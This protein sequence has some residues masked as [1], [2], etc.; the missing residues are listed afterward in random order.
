MSET[1]DKSGKPAPAT[2]TAAQPPNLLQF[3]TAEE[4]EKTKTLNKIYQELSENI[5]DFGF[6]VAIQKARQFNLGIKEVI[7]NTKG[8]DANLKTLQA[9]ARDVSDAM[10]EASRILNAYPQALKQAQ[11]EFITSAKAAEDLQEAADKQLQKVNELKRT[12]I[13]NQSAYLA[14]VAEE[15]K[16]LKD[17][18]YNTPE[19]N[20]RLADIQKQMVEMG[21]EEKN[22]ELEIE[23][24]NLRQLGTN[25]QIADKQKEIAKLEVARTKNLAEQAAAYMP[26]LKYEELRLKSLENINDGMSGF[27]NKITKSS[28][29]STALTDIFF[30]L[31]KSVFE[32]AGGIK[33]LF[34]NIT[35]GFMRSF[36][37]PAAA[38]NRVASFINK[39]LI[40]STIK[41]DEVLASVGKNTGGFRKEFEEV[42]IKLGGVSFAGLSEYGV[43]IKKF[44]EAYSGLSKQIGGFNNMLESQRKL[45]AE[46]AAAINTLGVSAD[47]YGK[48]VS[49]F[50]GALG[51]TAQASKEMINDLAKDAIGLSIEVGKYTNEFESFMPKL[52]GYGREAS[53]IFKELNGLIVAADGAI[54]TSDLMSISDRFKEFDSAADAVSKLNA[55]LGGTSVNILDMMKA[56]PADQIMM[57]KRAATESGLAFD[58]LNIGYK[59]LLAEYFGGDLKKAQAFFNADIVDAQR[60]ITAGEKELEERKKANVDFQEKLNALMENMKVIVTPIIGLMN[61]LAKVLT[62]IMSNPGTA[63]TVALITLGGLIT[64]LVM[65]WRKFSVMIPDTA[66]KFMETGRSIKTSIGTIQE[67]VG[68]LI[69][70]LNTLNQRLSATTQNALTMQQ[71]VRGASLGGGGNP[72]TA[73][74]QATMMSAPTPVTTAPVVAPPPTTPVVPPPATAASGMSTVGR[75][76]G[77][78]G[79]ALT[80]GMI[81]YGIGKTIGDPIDKKYG[82]GQYRQKYEDEL[83]VNDAELENKTI[84]KPNSRDTKTIIGNTTVLSKD[85]SYAQLLEQSVRKTSEQNLKFI[86]TVKE[87][88]ITSKQDFTKTL[89][90]SVSEPLKPIAAKASAE[91]GAFMPGQTTI[92]NQ[93]MLQNQ[94]P[95]KIVYKLPVEL[96]KGIAEYIEEDRSP[97]KKG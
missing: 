74:Q 66:R 24:I 44:G 14:L 51:K 57:I 8:L 88:E 26:M 15:S 30:G 19:E 72:A 17:R 97:L 77:V 86:Q 13:V 38:F 64:G 62:S 21:I 91:M 25:L 33:S 63:L 22:N 10:A 41:F 93:S 3:I 78:A 20:Q 2:P 90:K 84:I 53:K 60:Q 12:Q 7:E 46:D 69:T 32:G 31:Q 29:E 71:T 59:R 49:G 82:L 65:A 18:K 80:A 94:Q 1:D 45:L 47:T 16:L 87:S 67:S 42:A 28:T 61:G 6:E 9:D 23:K 54:S 83:E 5:K 76:L 68:L 36:T 40:D 75:V 95:T 85:I 4:I 96:V 70:E 79:L 89:E 52:I 58:S 37:D 55:M 81:G 27:L 73:L 50:M 92:Y 39:N 34:T 43:D 35:E 11:Q 48:L 56:D